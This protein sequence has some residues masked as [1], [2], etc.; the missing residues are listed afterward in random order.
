MRRHAR[1]QVQRAVDVNVVGDD[2]FARLS[3]HAVSAGFGGHVDDDGTVLHAPDH[4][5]GDDDRRFLAGDRGRGD[6]HVGLGHSLGQLLC[7]LCL[8][9]CC[10]FACVATGTIGGDAGVDKLGAERFD[11]L[12]RSGTHVVGF[13]HGAKP[14]AGGYR[15]QAGNA[16]ADHQHACRA[17][18]AG[19]SGQHREKLDA[20]GGGDQAALVTGAGGLRRKRIHA[21]CARDARQQ[22]EGKGGDLLR[23]QCREARLVLEG[24]EQPDEHA[25]FRQQGD[26]L[27]IRWR[28]A[29]D[30]PGSAV[31]F[32]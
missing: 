28:H 16:G 11:L 25:A 24:L 10:Q 27:S 13:D 4:V 20:A 17:D 3:H 18:G 29:H 7:L 5:G 30:Q 22:F 21:L 31:G 6:D 12:T 15:L 2:V 9:F 14:L 26:F 23:V 1:G 8:L 32:R 19:S